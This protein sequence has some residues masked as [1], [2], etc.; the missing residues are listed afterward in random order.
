MRTW[1]LKPNK[2]ELLETRPQTTPRDWLEAAGWKRLTTLNR[3]L[4]EFAHT[5]PTSRWTGAHELLAKLQIDVA[6]ATA[7]FTARSASPDFVSN[8]VA[9]EVTATLAELSGGVTPVMVELLTYVGLDTS[10]R[11]EPLRTSSITFGRSEQKASND[12]NLWMAL[13]E[14]G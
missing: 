9:H 14:V 8:L 5:K 7:I 12:Q 11:V 10:R 1:R 4:G 13:G 6:R 2:A 3:A